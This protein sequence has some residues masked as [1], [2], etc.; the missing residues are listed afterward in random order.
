MK[1]GDLTATCFM[2]PQIFESQMKAQYSSN[3][4]KKTPFIK[5]GKSF[6]EIV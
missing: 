3:K 2:G 5:C 6:S 1:D 4:K